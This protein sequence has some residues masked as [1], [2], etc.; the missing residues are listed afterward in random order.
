[1]AAG[2]DAPEAV[3][4]VGA[5]HYLPSSAAPSPAGLTPRQR[6]VLR[7]VAEGR[8]N[9]EIGQ[10]LGISARTVERHLSA[11][12]AATGANRRAAAVRALHAE[13]D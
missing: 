11:I 8:S 13:P 2:R 3:V 12:Y 5:C 9:R 10:A 7:L 4:L 6:D 1:M